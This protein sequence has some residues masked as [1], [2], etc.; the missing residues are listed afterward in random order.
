[1]KSLHINILTTKKYSDIQTSILNTW[2][3]NINDYIFYTDEINDIGNQTS[4]SHKS[5]YEYCGIKQLNRFKQIIDNK[6]YLKYDFFLFC[7][8]DTVINIKKIINLIQIL[9]DNYVYGC[10]ANTWTIDPTLYYCSGGAGFL[11]P[12]KL[13]KNLKIYPYQYPFN[14][15][16]VYHLY[17][18]SDVQAGLFFRDNDYECKNID[19][20][21]YSQPK[22]FYLDENNPN[23]K[24]KI[25]NAYSFHYIKNHEQ[26]KLITQIFND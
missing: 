2:L 10:R 1:M 15:E 21:Y 24:E 22:D 7:D 17:G 25:K 20:F 23:D 4:C 6:E 9:D 18:Y 19:G 13:F 16:K 14:D 26:R 8:D 3:K 5:S 11:V 12:S